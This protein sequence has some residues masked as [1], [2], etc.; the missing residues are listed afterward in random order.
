VL[1]SKRVRLS[2]SNAKV[3]REGSDDGRV[4]ADLADDALRTLA[5]DAALESRLEGCLEDCRGR[6]DTEDL[7][8]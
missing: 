2:G 1:E 8:L 6:G 7:T 4:R 3:V 5:G